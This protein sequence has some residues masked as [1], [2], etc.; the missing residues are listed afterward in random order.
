MLN[1]KHIIIDAFVLRPM[2]KPE[3]VVAWLNRLVS[4]VEMEVF[5]EARA[6]YDETPGN[7]GVTGDV[8]ITTSHASI[9]I[10][11]QQ[12]RPRVSFDLYSCK[13]FSDRD[14]I[15]MVK[16]MEATELRHIVIDRNHTCPGFVLYNKFTPVYASP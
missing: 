12:E 14:V 10:W 8:V 9:H 16:E 6:R 13:D 4:K 3:E 7:E 15:D 11:S 1:H 5:M 2:T